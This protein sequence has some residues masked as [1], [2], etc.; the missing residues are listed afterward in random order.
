MKNFWNSLRS[1]WTLG[2]I[3]LAGI[4]S[5]W[6]LPNKAFK[7]VTQELIALFGLMMAGVLPTMVLTASVLRAGNLSVKKLIDYRDALRRQLA[8][9]I[10]LFLVSLVASLLVI[11]GKMVEWSLVVPIPLAWAG[12][13]SSSFEVMRILNAFIVMA[14]AIVV[15][16]AIG[17][18]NGI[19][20]LLRLSAELAISEAQAR[21]D[22]RHRAAEASIGGMLERKG[23]GDYV[24]LKPH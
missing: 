7:E 8:V 17:V 16:R 11:V 1:H 18:G 13:E 22:A 20:S 21:E 19:I 3:V 15:F 2:A 6:L 14:L 10:G 4:L 24:E 23:Y 9:W 5:F 12:L